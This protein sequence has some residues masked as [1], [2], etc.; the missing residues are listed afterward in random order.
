MYSSILYSINNSNNSR[1]T[2]HT[3]RR[4]KKM[5]VTNGIAIQ[6]AVSQQL[7]SA[8][9]NIS[10][11][12]YCSYYIYEM[13]ETTLMTSH[14]SRHRS[15]FF[16]FFFFG[17]GIY[18]PFISRTFPACWKRSQIRGDRLLLDSSIRLTSTV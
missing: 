15:I 5:F 4:N 16:F 13:K 12:L 3:S 6:H 7:C 18:R 14:P 17:H 11:L 9:R 8:R 10:S 1:F 2:R